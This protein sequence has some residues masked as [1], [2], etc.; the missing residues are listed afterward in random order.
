MTIFTNDILQLPVSILNTPVQELQKQYKLVL[1]YSHV[2]SVETLTDVVE[3]YE[4]LTAAYETT[5]PD[6]PTS[7]ESIEKFDTTFDKS[8]IDYDDVNVVP[9]DYKPFSR[10][11]FEQLTLRDDLETTDE[12]KYKSM[13]I[14]TEDMPSIDLKSYDVERYREQLDE[15]ARRSKMYEYHKENGTLDEF[16]ELVE[17]HKQEDLER[18]HERSKTSEPTLLTNEAIVDESFL[19]LDNSE[20]LEYVNDYVISRDEALSLIQNHKRLEDEKSRTIQHGDLSI[21]L[22]EENVSNVPPVSK[23]IDEKPINK[24]TSVPT[25]YKSTWIDT[26]LMLGCLLALM[27]IIS[28][29]TSAWIIGLLS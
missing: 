22:P 21:T 25:N 14:D 7:H 8:M 28:M 10:I 13:D 3:S 12:S 1:R 17:Q 9:N 11:D 6:I 15:D 24:A 23:R 29:F 18:N 27:Y 19:K 26:L 20:A 5:L 4:Q 2:Y 16:Y